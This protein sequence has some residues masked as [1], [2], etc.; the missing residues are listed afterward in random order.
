MEQFL[1]L[2]CRFF[3]GKKVRPPKN[4]AVSFDGCRPMA[5]FLLLQNGQDD[6][7]ND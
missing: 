1:P 3:C 2:F 7:L 5:M 4:L 6:A